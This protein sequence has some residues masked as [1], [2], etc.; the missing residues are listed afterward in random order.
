M[1]EKPN[2]GQAQSAA[3][4]G[5]ANR[6]QDEILHTIQMPDGSDVREVTQ[7]EWRET[8]RDLGYIREPESEEA[9]ETT[10]EEP[11]ESPV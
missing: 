4:R 6:G 2:R 8:Y 10:P 11:E 5:K 1:A 9:D 3:S 7:R